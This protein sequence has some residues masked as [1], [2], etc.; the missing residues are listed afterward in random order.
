MEGALNNRHDGEKGREKAGETA[1]SKINALKRNGRMTRGTPKKRHTKKE[2]RRAE[3]TLKKVGREVREGEIKGHEG[4]QR[5]FTLRNTSIKNNASQKRG[6]VKKSQS[7]KYAR[8]TPK[9]KQA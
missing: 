2:A 8:R 7:E 3:N 4:H 9:T 1:R 5:I 6:T